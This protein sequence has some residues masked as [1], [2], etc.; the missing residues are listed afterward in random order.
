MRKIEYIPATMTPAQEWRYWARKRYEAKHAPECI[1][2]TQRIDSVS[3]ALD[4]AVGEV[5]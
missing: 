5:A 3:H 1:K 4:E 2:R